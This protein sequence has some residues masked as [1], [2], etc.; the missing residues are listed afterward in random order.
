MG[1]I[2]YTHLPSAAEA[3]GVSATNASL[4]VSAIGVSNTL[5]R[6]LAG[7]M[8]DQPWGQPIVSNFWTFLCLSCIFGLLTGMWVSA[9]P[10]AINYLLG[11]HLLGPAFG[12]LTAIRGC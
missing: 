1:Y 3:A 12:F 6:L 9:T 4:L 11:V 10:P 7:W 2:P 5:G 8:S